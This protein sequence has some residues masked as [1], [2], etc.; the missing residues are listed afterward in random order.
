HPKPNLIDYHLNHVVD[1]DVFK[2]VLEF[3]K[4][5]DGYSQRLVHD[6]LT[7]AWAT[8][9]KMDTS[10]TQKDR[11]QLYA[12]VDYLEGPCK[13]LGAKQMQNSC[14]KIKEITVDGDILSVNIEPESVLYSALRDAIE[15]GK[16]R[17]QSLERAVCDF[18][19]K[20]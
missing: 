12:D 19:A 3:D 13:V 16:E 4:H 5:D 8:F 7:V 2:E 14:T 10:L 15:Q 11:K 1:I 6:F 20:Q 17:L 9:T 18:Y